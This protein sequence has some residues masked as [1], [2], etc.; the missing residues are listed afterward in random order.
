MSISFEFFPPKSPESLKHFQT[1]ALQLA[2]LAPDFFSVTFGAGGSTRDGTIEA[3]KMLQEI[4]TIKVAPHLSCTGYKKDELV[5]IIQAYQSLGAKRVIALRGDLPSGMGRQVGEVPYAKD[6]V[7]LIRHATGDHFHIE[8]AAYPEF[9]PQSKSAYEDIYNLREKFE[10]GA[11]SAITQYFFNADAYFYFLD[12]C[13]KQHI[14]KPIIP[15]IMPITQFAK[16]ARFSEVCGAEIP[17]WLRKRLEGYGDDSDSIRSFGLEVIYNLSQRLISG[18]APGLHIYTLNQ[19]EESLI[20][21]NTLGS[22]Q[23]NQTT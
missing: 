16:L 19:A 12:E 11:D 21:F 23:L 9:H 2:E 18:G 4:T 6:L 3:I 7:A 10:A 22:Y 1:S 8:V 14:V 20:L 5:H 17:R 13:A 15:G